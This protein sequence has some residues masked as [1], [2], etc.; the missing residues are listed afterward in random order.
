M[1]CR[2]PSLTPPPGKSPNI[3]FPDIMAADDELFDKA[4]EGFTM[5]A[6]NSGEVCTCPSRA[7]IHESIFDAFMKRA[8]ERTKAIK[9]G[10]PLDTSVALGAQN[11]SLQLERIMSHL[12]TAHAEGAECMLGGVQARLEGDLA[13]GFYVEPT[14]FHSK[15]TSLK[16]FRDEVF[17]PV[18]AVT[19]FKTEEEA[20]AIAN[21][22]SYGLGAGVW[23]RDVN[24]QYRVSRA[25]KAGRIWANCYHAYPA[26]ATFGGYKESGIG[27]E[28]H[29]LALLGA[30][31]GDRGACLLTSPFRVYQ[32][33]S[34][35]SAS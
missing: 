31:L 9:K 15:D 14:I 24:V 8:L 35:S 25:I 33:T 32:P 34:R 30:F 29:K 18:I 23:A 26:G 5:F 6:F 22:T 27:R 4:L 11:S 16:I 21:D 10:N 13:G 17:G 12:T 20:I 2:T 1:L 28:T 7:L 19:T 3:F